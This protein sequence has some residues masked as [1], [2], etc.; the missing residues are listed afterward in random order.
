MKSIYLSLDSVKRKVLEKSI[1]KILVISG[2]NTYYKTG[3]DKKFKDI[4]QKKEIFL[5]IKN[6][7]F[8]EYKELKKIINYKNLVKPDLIIAI[9]GGC[10]MDYA[11]ICSVVSS[12][13]NLKEKII[14][15]DV[16]EKKNLKVLAIPTTTGSGAEVTSNAVIYINNIKFSVEG[17]SIKPDYYSIIPEF[18]ISSSFKIDASSGFDAISQAIESLFSQKSNN[19][20]ISFAKKSLK[21]LLK[22]YS[23]FLGNKNLNNSYKMA[24][25]ANLA[26][27]AISISKTTAPHALSYPFTALYNVPH[28]HAVSLTLNKFLKFNYFNTNIANCNFDLKERFQTLFSLTKTNNMKELDYFLQ[29]IKKK[30]KLEQ[31]FL[32][33]GFNI[34][35]DYHKIIKGLNEQRLKNNPVKVSISDIQHILKN[36]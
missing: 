1:K 33:L 15:S 14:N 12:Q 24:I 27:K 17:D 10:V 16:F 4:F 8:P 26:G 13:K 20:S 32:K 35:K 29:K 28:G 31:N 6:S 23:N 11:K 34:N 36:F 22:N 19:E 25:G 9:G 2:K 18:L 5:Y 7:K 30:G 21:I 3:A